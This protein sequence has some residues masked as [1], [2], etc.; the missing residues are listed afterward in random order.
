MIGKSLRD[1]FSELSELEFDADP[2][3]V[4][5]DPELPLVKAPYL[6]PKGKGVSKY[7]LVLDL[8][9]TLVHY[10]DVRFELR[11]FVEIRD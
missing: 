10:Y 9:E 1:D 7:T 3:R 8:D 11:L 5:A 4:H 2:L 6:Q